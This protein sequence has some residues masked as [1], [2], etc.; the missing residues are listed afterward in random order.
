MLNSIFNPER[1]Q[2]K[3]EGSFFQPLTYIKK[4]TLEQMFS[5]EFSEV[6]K[7]TFFIEQLRVIASVTSTLLMCDF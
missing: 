4:E 6:F 1:G 3:V 2:I 5:S 7:N